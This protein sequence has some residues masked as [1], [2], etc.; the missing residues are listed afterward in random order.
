V[1]TRAEL[2]PVGR[3]HA[4]DVRL[5]RRQELTGAFVGRVVQPVLRDELRAQLPPALEVEQVRLVEQRLGLALLDRSARDH[6][7]VDVGMLRRMAGPHVAARGR[8]E[9]PHLDKPLPE[10]VAQQP[11]VPAQAVQ[12]PLVQPCH[13]PVLPRGQS[14]SLQRAT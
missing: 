2:V 9:H 12:L 6:E 7:Q 14:P 5:D 11:A 8:P 10:P 13:N 1:A 4:A 3:P